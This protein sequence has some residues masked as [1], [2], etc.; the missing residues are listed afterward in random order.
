MN[1]AEIE[2][3]LRE[4]G[5]LRDVAPEDLAQFA[6]I[7]KPVEIGEGELILREGELAKDVYVILSG[8][9]SLEICAPGVGCRRFMTLSDGDLLS[10]SAV[11]DQTR[12]TATI[13]AISPIKAIIIDGRQLL[14]LCEHD[15]KFGFAFMRRVALAMAHRL[16]A[17]RMQL[18]NVFGTEMPEATG[19]DDSGEAQQ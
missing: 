3:A 5:F 8:K 19:Q 2:K 18:M 16:T 11:L 4:C 15:P 13:R 7:A 10:W 6:A 12:V 1:A 17:A 14:T 9:A